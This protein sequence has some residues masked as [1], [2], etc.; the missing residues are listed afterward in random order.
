MLSKSEEVV[1]RFLYEK[2]D[3]PNEGVR[4]VEAICAATGLS[5]QTVRQ[6]L[7][8]LREQK[9]IEG[10]P[11]LL[12]QVTAALHNWD[13]TP[14]SPGF[15]ERVIL[16]ASAIGKADENFLSEELGFDLEF[17]NLV[18]ARLR[19]SGIWDGEQLSDVS[20]KDWCSENGGATFELDALVAAGD[21]VVAGRDANGD[22]RWQMTKSGEKRAADLI[23]RMTDDDK[24]H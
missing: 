23:K 13:Y 11:D 21:L 22:R 9:M 15:A 24:N 3:E 19:N 7:R 6:A 2:R 18:G 4:N 12:A 14:T 8:S 16:L 10:P 17:V 5:T 20:R 1:L